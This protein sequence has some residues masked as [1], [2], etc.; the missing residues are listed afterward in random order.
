MCTDIIIELQ[1]YEAKFHEK[2]IDKFIITTGDFNTFLLISVKQVAKT[3][4]GYRRVEQYY[5]PICM[6]FSSLNSPLQNHIKY[7]FFSSNMEYSP[8]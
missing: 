8:R 7:T 3:Q 5:Q 6:C 4:K 1:I 2:K